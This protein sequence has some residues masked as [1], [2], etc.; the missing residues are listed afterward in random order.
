[1]SIRWILIG[2]V[3]LVLVVG[4]AAY[5][6]GTAIASERQ[7]SCPTSPSM[8]VPVERVYVLIRGETHERYLAC[9]WVGGD[10]LSVS[11]VNP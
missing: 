3:I 2:A 6:A 1:M 9:G 7:F 4:G 10:P 5:L 11:P 8:F